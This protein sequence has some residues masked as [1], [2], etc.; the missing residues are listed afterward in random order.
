MITATWRNSTAVQAEIFTFCQQSSTRSRS[1]VPCSKPRT[2]ALLRAAHRL[3]AG[4]A[5]TGK[6]LLFK[7]FY[8][9]VTA[10]FDYSSVV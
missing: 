7:V 8:I 3:L 1:L 6:Q 2:M 10:C 5:A 4:P 9:N